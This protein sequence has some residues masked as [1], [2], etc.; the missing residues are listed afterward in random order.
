MAEAHASLSHGRGTCIAVTRQRCCQ[1]VIPS[2]CHC[3]QAEDE[4]GNDGEM[5]PDLKGLKQ[6]QKGLQGMLQ[7]AIKDMCSLLAT[8]NASLKIVLAGIR[9]V[10]QAI[11]AEVR[12]ARTNRDD[13]FFLQGLYDGSLVYDGSMQTGTYVMETQWL[14]CLSMSLWPL[15]GQPGQ[16]PRA[17][18]STICTL[19]MC[20]RLRHVMVCEQKGAHS[21]PCA[22]RRPRHYWFANGMSS[23]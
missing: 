4:P 1:N 7:E 3:L 2:Q 8:A 10:L 23:S 14:C 5:V 16:R 11:N 22:R 19:A 12:N 20:K 15:A 6:M 17:N 13:M 18:V 21:E 9:I